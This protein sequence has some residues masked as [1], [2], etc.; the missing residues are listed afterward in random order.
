MFW[1]KW[2]LVDVHG[3]PVTGDLECMDEPV[4][5]T[6]VGV[7]TAKKTEVDER[8]TA[9]AC[10]PNNVHPGIHCAKQEVIQGTIAPIETEVDRV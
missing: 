5:K 8:S 9:Y 10:W 6:T 4:I 7:W 1:V 2:C 3:H